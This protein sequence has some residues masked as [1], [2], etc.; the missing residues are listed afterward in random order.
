M[1][2]AAY[3]LLYK[4]TNV[5]RDLLR[6]GRGSKVWAEANSKSICIIRGTSRMNATYFILCDFVMYMA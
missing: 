5:P 2:P 3:D 6:P 4:G 1:E